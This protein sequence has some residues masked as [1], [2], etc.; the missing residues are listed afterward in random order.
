M[1]DNNKK[2]SKKPKQKRSAFKAFI[3]FLIF[4][5]LIGTVVV[6]AMVFSII[7]QAPDIDPAAINSSLD[8]TSSIYDSEGNLLERIDAAE[9]RT[10]VS[11]TTMPDHLKEAFI[12]IEDERFYDHHGIDPRGIMSSLVDNIKAG[13]IVRGASTITQQLVKNVYLTNEKKLD[14][15]IKE[16]YLAI[17]LEN[18]LSKDQILEAYLNRNFFGQ[19]AYGVQEAAQTYFS[20][21]VDELTIA[22][23]AVLAGV[24]KNINRFQPYKRVLPAEFN[25]EV[26]FKVGDINIHGQ[27]YILVFNEE[28]LERQQLVLKK[29]RD[30]NYITE[31]EYQEAIN[32]D[33]KTSLKPV[34]KKLVEITSYFSD[35][36]KTETIKLLQTELGLNR[37]QAEERLFTGGLKIYSTINVEMQKDLENVY[38]NFTEIL[39]GNVANTRAPVLIDWRLNSAGNIIDDS[40]RVIFYK[41]QNILDDNWNVFIEEG[42]YGISNEGDLIIDNHKLKAYPKHI[43]IADFYRIDDRKNLVTHTVGSISMDPEEFSVNEIGEIVIKK[44]F[45][46]KNQGFYTINDRGQLLINSANFYMDLDGAV[47]PQSASVIMDYRTGH[48]K[49]V[50]G[51]RDLDGNRI[52][53]RATNSLRQPGSVIKPISVYL[54]ALD[55]GY[56]AATAIDDVPLFFNGK[57][58]PQNWYKGYR[59]LQTLRYSVEQSINVNSVQTLQSI[60]FNTSMEYLSKMG[61]INKQNPASDNFVSAAENPTANDEN[62]SALA[63]GGMSK[64]LTPLEMTAAYAAIAN[65]GVYISPTPISKILDKDGSVLVDSTPKETVVVSPQIAYIMKDILHTTV[66][67]GIV[68]QAQIPNFAV[69]GKTGTTQNQADIWFV[70]FTPYYVSTVWIGN[71]SPTITVN[72][73]SGTAAQLWKQI[74]IAAHKNLEP[75]NSFDRPEGIVSASICTQSG[76]LPSENCASDPRGTIK[77][78]IFAAGT[79]PTKTCDVHVRVNIDESTGKVAN[80]YCPTGSV[81]S[82][83]FVKRKTP[84]KASEHEGLAPADIG[85]SIPEICNV[86]S[87]NSP[88]INIE[89]DP[90]IIDDDEIIIDENIDNDNNQPVAP[91]NNNN[92]NDNGNNNNDNH[93]DFDVLPIDPNG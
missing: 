17:S 67:Q 43:D 54:P 30:L 5:I 59:G 84:Y 75:K 51:G 2:N 13:R 36:V 4:F 33:I 22:E 25:E 62:P 52:L 78:E 90:E 6:S 46:D 73:G 42:T 39:V 55:N 69:A 21:N 49:A 31:A 70:G 7:R 50:V 89:E 35:F 92:T 34:E 68:K 15:K 72:R 1:A 53:N 26:Q 63:L 14:R 41:S 16:A 58:W 60:G 93:N 57:L 48:L 45:L 44:S 77:T 3:L 37:E 65:D 8:Q 10:F 38:E 66:T 82:R 76:L 12:A 80:D 40:D 28:T 79:V 61:I 24:V 83:V 85:Y 18:K 81:S 91:D 23:S 56:T 87:A 74:N 47:Q 86:H 20:K 27:K 9:Y 32:Q 29:M 19:N 88:G 64:G 11:L 71:D